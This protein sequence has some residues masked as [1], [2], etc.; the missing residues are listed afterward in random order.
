MKVWRTVLAG[1]LMADV[2]H[3]WSVKDLGEGVFW[4]FWEWVGRE[5]LHFGFKP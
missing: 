3:L 4:K 5:S 1:L 2:G